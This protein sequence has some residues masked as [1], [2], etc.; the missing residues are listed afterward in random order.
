MKRLAYILVIVAAVLLPAVAFAVTPSDG[1]RRKESVQE[2]VIDFDH[3]Y[4][5]MHLSMKLSKLKTLNKFLPASLRREV[6][7][8]YYPEI[9]R[10]LVTE[11]SMTFKE[12]K[13]SI[14]R[15]PGGKIKLT[16]SF[17]NF[18]MV[19]REATWEQ[20]DEVFAEYF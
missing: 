6:G 16:L 13:A 9:R 20:I 7:G 2:P 10:R 14:E 11:D 15:F 5:N 17:P 12:G 8:E 19:I 1:A 3:K 4:S 18:D